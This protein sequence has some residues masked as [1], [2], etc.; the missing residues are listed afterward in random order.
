MLDSFQ[1]PQ[2]TRVSISDEKPLHMRL[3]VPSPSEQGQYRFQSQ[4]RSRST[5]DEMPLP[6]CQVT[7][8]VSISDE[9]PLHMR[10]IEGNFDQF[11]D[12]LF[13]SQM[14]SRST[15]DHHKHRSLLDVRKF[16]SQ[17]RSR[18]TCDHSARLPILKQSRRFNLR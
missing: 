4:M 9:K 6:T 17:M 1:C 10:P 16:Q 13:Q 3:Y 14:R 11:A 12:E 8:G 18:S 5:C 15:C 2:R 7:T